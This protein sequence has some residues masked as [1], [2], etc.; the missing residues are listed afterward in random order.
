MNEAKLV[1]HDLLSH[2]KISGKP[3]LLLANKQDYYNALD[4]ID[5]AEKLELENLVNTQ[6]CPTLVESCSAMNKQS[7]KKIDPG[8]KT[9]YHWLINYISR[10]YET[11]NE[12]VQKDVDEQLKREREIRQQQLLKLQNESKE[13]EIDVDVNKFK[14]P[15][16]PIKELVTENNY[17]KILQRKDFDRSRPNSALSTHS[18]PQNVVK[19]K[20][21]KIK[22]RPKS[23]IEGVKRQLK[24]TNRRK[25][26]F[27]RNSNKTVPTVLFTPKK[28]NTQLHINK[29]FVI[30]N[31]HST[32]EQIE[33]ALIITELPNIPIENNTNDNHIETMFTSNK[34]KPETPPTKLPP[35][36]Y[37]K[38]N[39]ISWVK[40]PLKNKHFVQDDIDRIYKDIS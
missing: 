25:T 40:K 20:E 36:I 1:L 33:D 18:T 14:N 15:F 4:E 23:A 35:I 16:K 26:I 38:S 19:K 27:S 5:I 7:S 6:K 8:I 11:L 17:L 32:I 9:G 34:F 2:E 10:E 28:A 37:K 21:I 12:R 22:E 31:G 29:V 3:V 30:E 24:K 13:T 39:D